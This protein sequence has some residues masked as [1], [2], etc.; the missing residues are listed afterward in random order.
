MPTVLR[1]LVFTPDLL[2]EVQDFDC[3]D[4]PW[5]QEVAAWIKGSPGGVLDDLQRGC[6]VW[7]YVTEEE[8]LVGFGSLARSSWRWPD[9]RRPNT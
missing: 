9:L 1:K 4:E 8:G 3:G 6:E 5:E 7:L 2:P